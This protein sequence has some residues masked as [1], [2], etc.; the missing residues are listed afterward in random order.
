MSTLLTTAAALA[1]LATS[2]PP[3]TVQLQ[4]ALRSA[5]GLSVDGNYGMDVRLFGGEQGG[6]PLAEVTYAGVP[7]TDGVFTV[8]LQPVAPAIFANNDE[9]WA[10]VAV[11][12][13]PPLPRKRVW[14]VPMSLLSGHSLGLSCSGC[15][16]PGH[17]AP[18]A[19]TVDKLGLV[20][21]PGQVLEY[22]DGWGCGTDDAGDESPW[23]PLAGGIAY[24]GG[25]V[26]IGLTDPQ[27]TLSVAG[28]IQVGPTIDACTVALEGALRYAATDKNVEFCDGD[29]WRPLFSPPKDGQTKVQAALSCKA[30]RDGGFGAGDDTYWIDPDGGDAAD[31]FQAWCDMTTDGGGWTL[32]GTISGAGENVWTTNPGVWGDDGTLGSV[33]EP[34]ADYK[35]RAWNELDIGGAEILYQRRWAG[36]V[37]AQVKFSASCQGTKARFRELFTTWDTSIKCAQAQVT[38]V[39]IPT[40]A[41]GLADDVYREG[42]SEVFGPASTGFC[43]S[44]G[45]SENNKFQGR[46]MS[47]YDGSISCYYK[48]HYGPGVGVFWTSGVAQYGAEYDDIE[49]TNMFNGVDR[50]KVDIQLFAR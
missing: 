21:A 29:E 6:E 34:F 33:D 3:P 7:V 39:L 11:A 27:A 10:E 32:L 18:G 49:A 23:E 17:L 40:D 38:P 22:S 16:G 5:G 35:S 46:I 50:T 13:E 43:W 48:G 12:G 1:A 47:T 44:G 25:K 4:G 24:A 26:G 30:I 31:A 45:D 42:A 20:C 28:A 36:E 2:G 19:V 14:A 41:A 37:K 8:L 9:V 15:V